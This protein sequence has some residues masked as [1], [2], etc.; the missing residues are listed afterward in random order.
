MV[1]QKKLLDKLEKFNLDNFP[2]SVL[3]LGDKGCGKHTYLNL[4]KDKL[5]LPLFDITDVV[6]F[7]YILNMYSRSILTMYYIDIDKFT[8]KKQNVVLKLLEEPPANAYLIILCSDK[9]LVLPTVLNRCTIFEFEKYSKTELEKFIESGDDIDL[10]CEIFSTPGQLLSSNV[11]TIY[12]LYE[13]CCKI[14]DKIQTSTYPNAITISDK[15]N[16]NDEYDKFDLS[17]FFNMMNHV[18]LDKYIKKSDN[19]L[20]EY[21]NI[22]NDYEKKFSQDK[23]LDKQR[24]FENYIGKLWVTSRCN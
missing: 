9:S 13:L 24:L 14:I 3:L 22:T 19:R 18:I 23:R 11:D 5:N 17:S 10:M 4:I 6:D 15:I 2:R 7:D 20:I 12:N 8:E 1:G 16:Y 21:M